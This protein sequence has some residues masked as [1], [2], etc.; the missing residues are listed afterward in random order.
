MVQTSRISSR[1]L[2]LDFAKFLCAF[3]VVSIHTPYFGNEYL[4][5]L[6]RFAVPVF[7]MI[8]GY[9]YSSVQQKSREHIQLRKAV[10]LFLSSNLLFLIW[11]IVLCVVAGESFPD[12]VHSIF[13]FAT[14]IKFLF[15]SESILSGHLWYL[16]ALS[17]VLVI[18]L[19][20]DKYSSREKLYKFIPILLLINIL[21]G[22]YSIILFGKRL[23]LLLTRNFL[24]CGLP[25]FLLGDAIS[26]KQTT[27]SNA[28]LFAIAIISAFITLAENVVF[29]KIE[30]RSNADCF[31]ATPFLAYSLFMLFL[32][33][34]TTFQHPLLTKVAQLGRCT[35]TT[36]YIIHP[37]A[38]HIVGKIVNAIGR[39][40]PCMT[41]VWNYTAPLLVFITCTLFACCF[42]TVRRNIRR[43]KNG[44]K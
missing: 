2:G 40:V 7:F 21:V 16:G 37:I 1:H 44:E 11:K 26:R 15:F 41:S 29:L 33:N 19:V 42:D 14:W 18:I 38:I 34:G 8:T 25:F 4:E 31:F 32:K 13:N 3:M 10:V 30:A 28:Q 17:Y 24:F 22:N 36:T 23:P 20:F 35:A 12:L 27:R 5:P 43:T 6:A 9:F 39:Y